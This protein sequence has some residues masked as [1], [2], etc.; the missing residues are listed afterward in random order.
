MSDL[1]TRISISIKDG[2]LEFEGSEEFVVKQIVKYEN[3]IQNMI[4]KTVQS[5]VAEPTT[6]KNQVEPDQTDT[7]PV[8]SKINYE[9]VLAI[10]D[11]VVKVLSDIPDK[12]NSKKTISAALLCL[13]A[14]NIQGIEEVEFKEIQNICKEHS[15]YDSAH[16][17]SYLK[18]DKQ[19]KSYFIFGGTG[20]RQTA[21]LTFPGKRAA[22]N[23]VKELNQS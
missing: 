6:D 12:S 21:K 13:F 3:L 14:K 20:R 8:Q 11:N 22:E 23:L 18:K 1:I 2:I 10:E 7:K 17:S 4:S 5:Q 15:C 16:F 19:A 9:N